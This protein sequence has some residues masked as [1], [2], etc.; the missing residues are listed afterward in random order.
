M[1]GNGHTG[2]NATETIINQ[3]TAPSLHVHWT[4]PAGSRVFSQ[5]VVANGM[6]YW[7][8]WDG[9]E[10]ASTLNGT[11]V[12]TQFVGTTTTS[13]GP[14]GIDGQ[15]G[16]T[17]VA[18]ETINGTMTGVAFVPGGDANLYALDALT[19]AIIWQ[20]PLGGP[21]SSVFL[22]DSPSVFNGSVYIGTASIGDCPLIQSQVVKADAVSGT[23]Q[24]TFNIVPPGCIGGSLW[25]SLTLD[26]AAGTLYFATGNGA[27]CTPTESNALALVKLRA[28]DLSYIS[29]WQLPKAER[30]NDGDFGSTPTLFQ[31]TINGAV[32]Q[33]VGVANKNG[34]YYAFDRNAIGNGPL[35]RASIAVGGTC[36]QCGKGSISPSAWD[37]TTLYVAGGNTTIN[38]GSCLG[39]VRALDP[40]TGAFL[41]QDCFLD[42]PV[43]AAVTTVPGVVM[44]VEGPYLTLVNAM[45]GQSLF[46]SRGSTD[47][48]RFFGAVSVSNGVLYLGN[49]DK[50][51]YAFGV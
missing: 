40:A 41:W 19:G 23:L 21:T 15:V 34:T 36:P 4:A 29:S 35:W 46:A 17:T 39:S 44:V 45:S 3:T 33:M 37:G 16:T 48:S 11:H 10:H 42:G 5:P 24:N 47:K 38:G 31:A 13:C 14:F 18:P 28:S 12:W 20:L 26:E 30:Q 51:L 9:F 22:W 43:L 8:S 6:I 25:G 7:G 27:R 2:Y 1:N 50:S 32:V 49:Q